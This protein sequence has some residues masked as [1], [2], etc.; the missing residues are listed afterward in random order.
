MARDV[1]AYP[2][3]MTLVGKLFIANPDLVER[4]SVNGPLNEPNPETFYAHG[5]EGYVDYPVL[6][7]ADG[8]PDTG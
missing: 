7:P 5:P 2:L 8:A 6:Q 3:N 4:F 1:S